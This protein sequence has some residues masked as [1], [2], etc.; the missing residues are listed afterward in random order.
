M[1][2]V[3]QMFVNFDSIQSKS[4]NFTPSTGKLVFLVLSSTIRVCHS[5][6]RTNCPIY[7][8]NCQLGKK[9]GRNVSSELTHK[10]L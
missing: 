8:K 10:R 6:F 7:Q 3:V 4:T 2:K 5:S 9:N 1:N